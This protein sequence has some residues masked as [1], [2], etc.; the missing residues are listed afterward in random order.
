M[1][2]MVKII[3]KIRKVG[4]WKPFLCDSLPFSAAQHT[5]ESHTATALLSFQEFSR[6]KSMSFLKEQVESGT[7]CLAKE[8]QAQCPL[9]VAQKK[10]MARLP[11][12]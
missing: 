3:K 9:T 1:I 5:N 10:A 8:L 11:Q 7:R 4:A 2:Q 6:Q 12:W